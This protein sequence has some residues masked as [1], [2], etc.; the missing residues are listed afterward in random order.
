MTERSIAAPVVDPSTRPVWEAAAAG[1]LLLGLCRDT[2]RHFHYPRPVSPF[3]LSGNVDLVP[4]SGLGTIY[5]F[6][7]MRVAQPYACAYVELAEGP[8]I[9]TNIVDCAF[10][11]IRIGMKVRVVF[12]PS[13]A[14]DGTPGAPVPMFAPA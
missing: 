9:F 1:R 4:A 8:R 10:E 14:A 3:T 2:G 12:R 6:T 5:S 7:V 13:Q 11:E